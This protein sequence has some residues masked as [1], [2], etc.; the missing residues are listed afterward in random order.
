MRRTSLVAPLLLIVL[1][2]LLLARTL[3]PELQLMDYVSRFWPLALIVWGGLQII[4]LVPW[5]AA[6]K[7]L[8]AHGISGGEWVLIVFLCLFGG[9]L[10]AVQGMSNWWPEHVRL[11]G[12]DFLGGDRYEYP[13]SGEKASSAAPR[14]LIEDFRG[15]A[16]INGID[17]A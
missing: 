7:P 17:A 11:N 3:Y 8:P 13:L 2:A 6:S 1:G 9:S 12:L 4:E 14:V 10:H 5:A 15:D 16:K